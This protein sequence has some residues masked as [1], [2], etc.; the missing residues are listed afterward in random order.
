MEKDYIYL[1][2]ENMLIE[3][4]EKYNKDVI[5]NA[6]KYGNIEDTRTCA[7]YQAKQFLSCM[8]PQKQ[9]M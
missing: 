5:T 7:E 6:E 1:I 8:N 9:G 4:F 3:A 2:S